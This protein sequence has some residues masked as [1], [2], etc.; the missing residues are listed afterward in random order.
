[1]YS[2]ALHNVYGGEEYTA[3]LGVVKLVAALEH[4]SFPPS[5]HPHYGCSNCKEISELFLELH[6]ILLQ[7]TIKFSDSHT[8]SY[9]KC[10]LPLYSRALACGLTKGIS[11]GQY[12]GGSPLQSIFM[13]FAM[14]INID[15]SVQLLR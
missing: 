1:M 14:V 2:A 15:W 8:I 11:A 12:C 10:H 9:G 3:A 7:D 4:G 6:S 5:K 13:S